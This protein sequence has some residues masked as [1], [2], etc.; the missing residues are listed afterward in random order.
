VIKSADEPYLTGGP[1]ADH[2]DCGGYSL[3]DVTIRD[4]NPDEGD[5]TTNCD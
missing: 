5:T 1:G 2:F 4:F 3:L